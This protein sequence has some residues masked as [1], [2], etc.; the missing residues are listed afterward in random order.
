[1]S[2]SLHRFGDQGTGS[3]AINSFCRK[4]DQLTTP[5]RV[6]GTPDSSIGIGMWPVD[7]LRHSS[8]PE[9]GKALFLIYVA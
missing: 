7:N 1:L 6:N 9:F 4:C 2:Q 3:N 8:Y 5:Q